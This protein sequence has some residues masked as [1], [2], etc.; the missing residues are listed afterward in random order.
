MSLDE[1]QHLHQQLN[2]AMALERRHRCIDVMGKRLQFSQFVFQQLQQLTRYELEPT[3][4]IALMR[5]F[6]RYGQLDVSARMQCLEALEGY[7]ED[8]RSHQ[9]REQAKQQSLSLM[10]EMGNEAVAEKVAEA[11]KL[12]GEINKGLA[13]DVQ[14]VKGIGPKWANQLKLSGIHTVEQLLYWFPRDYIDYQQ[15]RPIADLQEGETASL[16]GRV[17]S[18]GQFDSKKRQ[19]TILNLTVVDDSGRATASWFFKKHQQ[20]LIFNFRQRFPKGAEV[21]L[22]GRVKWDAYKNC[23]QID[24]PEIQT[25]SYPNADL[26]VEEAG[27]ASLHAGRI[28]PIYPLGQG[29]QLKSLRRAIHNALE[30]F[31]MQVE[32]VVPASIRS[33]YRMLDLGQALQ[34]IHFPEQMSHTE[35]ARERLV[36]DEFFFLQL[37]L[38]L[39]RAQYKQHVQG[40]QL[41]R[42]PG[43]Y[44]ERFLQQL[45]F[46]LTGAQQRA[47]EDTVEDMAKA[48][49]MNRLL[50]WHL[51]T[52]R[53][54]F[55]E[56]KEQAVRDGKDPSKVAP[57]TPPPKGYYVS[58]ESISDI[59]TYL[60]IFFI[61]L[62][63]FNTFFSNFGHSIGNLFFLFQAKA[64]RLANKEKGVRNSD[65]DS[66]CDLSDITFEEADSQEPELCPGDPEPETQAEPSQSNE[67]GSEDEEVIGVSLL[68]CRT[69]FDI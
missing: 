65:D 26:L 66:E 68:L 33:E 27:Q 9:A 1:A 10:A 60:S 61:Y 45:P 24:R 34:W 15:H 53:K 58:K 63:R 39:L 40:L 52:W 51:E 31:A 11:T 38:A 25:L 16:I 43:G 5:R 36:F 18:V 17:H 28:V 7:L 44:L 19:L 21:L 2:Q 47:F 64:R 22:S 59:D 4:L 13:S 46:Q 69:E 8:K 48:E 30:Q 56:K 6:E 20:G 32:D 23:P 35:Q 42:R 41:Q 55:N 37:R 3:E 50:H 67:S 49:P 14:W 54:K 29:L 62:R 57:P 12:S